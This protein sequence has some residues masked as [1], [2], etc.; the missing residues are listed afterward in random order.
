MIL[1]A[2]F[3]FVETPF[4]CRLYNSAGGFLHNQMKAGDK[5]EQ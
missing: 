5:N 2:A 4:I 3:S 1:L